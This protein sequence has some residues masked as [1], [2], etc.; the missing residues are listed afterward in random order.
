MQKWGNLETR[1]PENFKV[2]EKGSLDLHSQNEGGK[3]CSF[4]LVEAMEQLD[5]FP[6]QP[7]RSYEFSYLLFVSVKLRV[8]FFIISSFLNR[9]ERWEENMDETGKYRKFL[10]RV[11]RFLLEVGRM[12]FVGRKHPITIFIILG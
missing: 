12:F 10:L 11:G 2:T 4:S 5:L 7:M 9:K 1:F 8:P 3:I 6:D